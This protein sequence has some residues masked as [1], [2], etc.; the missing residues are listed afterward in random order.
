MCSYPFLIHPH[1]TLPATKLQAV[2]PEMGGNA[3][4]ATAAGAADDFLPGLAAV[5]HTACTAQGGGPAASLPYRLNF[6]G[7]CFLMPR[8]TPQVTERREKGVV[9]EG[10]HDIRT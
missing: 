4:G 9:E 10:Y 7:F 6:L 5:R 2:E 3:P 1:P 8:R